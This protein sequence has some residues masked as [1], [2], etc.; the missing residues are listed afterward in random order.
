MRLELQ[1]ARSLPI[2]LTT[3][4][5]M[6]AQDVVHVPDLTLNLL[7]VHKMVKQGD[8]SV[9]FDVNGCRLL[10]RHVQVKPECILATGT[11]VNG[12]YY[13]NRCQTSSYVAEVEQSKVVNLWHRRL[14]HLSNSSMQQL[15]N[16]VTGVNNMDRSVVGPCEACVKG[17]QVRVPFKKSSNKRSQCVLGLVH[18]DVCG[19]MSTPSVGGARYFLAFTDD[20]TRHSSVDFLRSKTEV[21]EK[22]AEYKALV[23]N[24]TGHKIKALRSDNGTEYVNE[25][26]SSMLRSC[27]IKHET[28]V[29][30]S[31][32]QNNVAERLSRTLVE[33]GR[34]ML[35][36][37]HLSVDLWAEAIATAVY[38]RN[39]SPTKALSA[40]TAE[41]AWS[42][43]KPD[44][45][46]RVFGC[47]AFA[48]T[49]D[50][51]RKKW[52]AKSQ[53]FIFVGYCE[54]TKG[55]RLVHPVTK[56]AYK[57]Q[58]CCVL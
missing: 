20:Y 11:Q 33:R 23:E 55:Y 12:M 30:Y 31:P 42:G 25:R 2:P 46:L 29:P 7:S 52:D 37:S 36:E 43:H 14:G 34:S 28:T 48:K 56:K 40:V 22:F 3:G 16:M 13:L 24:Q 27:G 51:H 45:H 21:P 19:P 1:M 41:K 57:V 6:D 58:R 49:P 38:L 18:S 10:N 54:E 15:R 8:R 50:A 35:M 26:L 17:K 53:E 44:R 9:I 5:T 4:Y 32:Q 47:R 39:R